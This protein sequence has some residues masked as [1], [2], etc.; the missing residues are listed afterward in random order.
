MMQIPRTMNILKFIALVAAA[1]TTVLL[2]LFYLDVI[3]VFE[4][5][6]VVDITL[7]MDCSIRPSDIRYRAIGSKSELDRMQSASIDDLDEITA[8]SV[9]QIEAMSATPFFDGGVGHRWI[10]I[11]VQCNRRPN[12]RLWRTVVEVNKSHLDTRELNL[13]C[14]CE[15]AV[16]SSGRWKL[17]AVE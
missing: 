17:S 12:L 14:P 5:I 8:D 7:E 16:D 10:I 6:T 1:L 2:G 3:P 11:A 9:I 4:K 15:D 13:P